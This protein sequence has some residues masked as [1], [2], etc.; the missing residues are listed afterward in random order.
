[1]RYV[2]AA[3]PKA[4]VGLSESS[5]LA[6]IATRPSKIEWHRMRVPGEDDE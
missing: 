2:S 3:A 6:S 5:A 1:M 4:K